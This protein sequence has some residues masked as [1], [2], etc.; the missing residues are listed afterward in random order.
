MR[1][2]KHVIIG[3]LILMAVYVG[4]QYN[5]GQYPVLHNF[6]GQVETYLHGGQDAEFNSVQE[7]KSS[8][9]QGTG[10]GL[11]KQQYN[12]LAN[13]NFK[14]GSSP[15][16]TVNNNRST[17]NP[18]SWKYN[19]VVYHN[20]DN[21]NRT[22]TNTGYLEARN[23]TGDSLRVRQYVMPTGWHQKKINGV[24]VVNRGHE[25]AYSVS[26]GIDQNG[27]YN[28]EN[29]S[30]DQNNPKNLFTQ[31]AF[32]NQD[33]QTKYEQMIRQALRSGKKVVYQVTPIFRGNELM[34]RGVNLQAVSTDGA[35]NF[36]VYIY[37]VQPGVSFNYATGRSYADSNVRVNWHQTYKNF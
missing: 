28:P 35:F 9:Y 2:I 34:A 5:E 3:L 12:Q 24:F 23:V 30:G 27:Q 7:Q 16:V 26:A 21:L 4:Y 17:L 1:K 32:A 13:L 15:V 8:S 31:T 29:R 37:N 25:I 11:T 22:G 19:H 6:V 36:N 20:L 14:S 33:V 10:N 18:H